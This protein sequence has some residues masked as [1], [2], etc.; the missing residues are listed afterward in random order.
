MHCGVVPSG[1]DGLSTGPGA[2][3]ELSMV[4]LPGTLCLLALLIGWCADGSH[5]Q[6]SA[7]EVAS[8]IV[9][10]SRLAQ[11]RE[12]LSGKSYRSDQPE[13]IASLG[14]GKTMR[15]PVQL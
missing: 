1:F 9:V 7:R 13:I 6:S 11:E 14:G 8:K 2:V 15:F 5:A 3:G 12:H 4:R 10:K